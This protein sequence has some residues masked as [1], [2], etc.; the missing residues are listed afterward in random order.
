MSVLPAP[1]LTSVRAAPLDDGLDA[2]ELLGVARSYAELARRVLRNDVDRLPAVR[3]VA[4]HADAVPEVNA[5]PVDEAKRI[6]AGRK[7]AVAGVRRG[8]RVRGRP[9]KLERNAEHRKGR[10]SEEIAV[11]RV[12]HHGC[13]DPLERACFDELDLSSASFL[14]G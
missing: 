9:V 5:L 4:V 14:R 7:R 1:T 12:E 13:V 2:R 3:D 11:E 10:V 8:R 6:H